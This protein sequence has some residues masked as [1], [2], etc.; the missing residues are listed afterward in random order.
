[1]IKTFDLKKDELNLEF[2]YNLK[3]TEKINSSIQNIR[4]NKEE[5][6]IDNLRQIALW[7][8]NRVVDIP[9]ELIKQLEELTKQKNLDIN[10][11]EIKDLIE[12]LVSCK[13][14]GYP[15]AST[16]L[17]FIRPDKFPIIDARAYRVLYGK[18]IYPRQYNLELYYKYIE[19]IKK[20]SKEQKIPLNQVDE[21][22][23]L[24]DKKHNKTL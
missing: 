23:Y 21:Q 8:I 13:G 12:K 3:E 19:V 1:M 9:Q 14:V 2:D 20:I 6:K 24:F 22:L 10:N 7:K 18:K 5:L 15:M 16:I 11:Q 17:K 4:E